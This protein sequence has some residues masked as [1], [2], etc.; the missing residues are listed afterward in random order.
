MLTTFLM[1]ISIGSIVAAIVEKYN[2]IKNHSKAFGVVQSL[3]GLMG[4][5]TIILFS[6]IDSIPIFDIAGFFK[7]SISWNKLIVSEILL[8]GMIIIVPTI[9]MG[10][11]FPLVSRIFTQNIKIVGKTIGSIYSVNTI[12]SILGSS[13]TGFILVK[14]LGTQRSIIFIS[15]IALTI[16]TAIV[17]FNRG[18]IKESKNSKRFPIIF[19]AVMWSIAVGLIVWLPKDMLFKYYNIYEEQAFTDAQIIYASEGIEGI[20]TVH[21][22]PG[23]FRGISTSSVNVAGT[24]YTHRTTQ[25]LQAHIPMLVHP[26]PKEVLQVGFGSGETSYLVTTYDID[27]L[28][29]VEI[30]SDVID[31]STEYFKDL[32]H[33]VAAHP[34]FNPIIMDGANYIY[35]TNKKYDVILNDA[36]WPGYT[37]SSALYSKDYFE[38]AKKLLKTGG[39]MTSWF[40]ISEGEDFKIL[41]KTFHSVFPYVS[42]WSAMTHVNKHALVVGSLHK[43]EIDTEHFLRRFIQYAQEDLQSVDLDNPLFFMDAY[44]VDETVFDNFLDDS[45]PTHTI[46]QPILEFTERIKDPVENISAYRIMV[47]NNVSIVPYLITSSHIS[48]NGKDF[49]QSLESTRDATKLV[50]KGYIRVIGSGEY[51]P[52]FES[53]FKDALLIDPE[54]PGANHFFFRMFNI[55]LTLAENYANNLDHNNAAYNYQLALEEM[56]FYLSLKPDSARAYHNRGL[57]YL[58]GGDYLGL[59]REESLNNAQ[60]DL[61]RALTLSPQYALENDIGALINMID[62]L[63]GQ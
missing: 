46:D 16:G 50:M 57:I 39:I 3:I 31:T 2:L 27:Q 58:N 51:Q 11:T 45:I 36:S 37:G 20:T 33:D 22:Y 9:F 61:S 18:G 43:I 26:N 1:G 5:F 59:T 30:S 48:I 38:N 52:K 40:P 10:M 32:N 6:Q 62:S 60:G 63:L 49:L 24:H 28:D 8:S 12:G 29:L 21:E 19:S 55:H 7:S 25:K 53:E 23:G 34:K 56:N 47:E 41:L 14:T 4:L 15:L 17:L 42:A 44:Q 13:L 35:L 54:H